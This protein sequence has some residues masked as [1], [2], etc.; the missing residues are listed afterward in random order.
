MTKAWNRGRKRQRGHRWTSLKG[1]APLREVVRPPYRPDPERGRG[2][3]R[4]DIVDDPPE[5]A[6]VPPRALTPIERRAF[7]YTALEEAMAHADAAVRRARHRLAALKRGEIPPSSPEA[8]SAPGDQEVYGPY[9]L[10]DM[11]VERH[12]VP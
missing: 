11:A 2:R 4:H 8:A 3:P 6:P 1:L 9:E 12:V 10:D 7:D 5:M